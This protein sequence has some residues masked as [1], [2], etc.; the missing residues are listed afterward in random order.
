MLTYRTGAIAGVSGGKAMAAH[1]MEATLPREAA[2]LAA[3]YRAGAEVLSWNDLIFRDLA[4]QVVSGTLAREDAEAKGVEIENQI[5]PT[6]PAAKSAGLARAKLDA[7][8]RSIGRGEQAITA[9]EPRADM[10]PALA[11]R[12]GIDPTRSLSGDELANLLAGWCADG[13]PIEGASKR[14]TISFVDCCFSADKSVSLAWAFAPTE[15]ERNQIAQAHRD[16]VQSAMA[17]ASEQ[18]GRA[19]KGN[20]GKGGWEP[21]HVG[22]AQFMHYTSRPTLEI[23]N[24]AETELVSL[25]V[26]GDPNLHTHVTLFNAVLTDS[27]RFGSLDLQRLKGRVHEFGAYYQAHL[28]QNLRAIGAD[29]MLDQQTGAARLAAIPEAV[30]TAF[31]KRTV[32]A[33]TIARRWAAEAGR[34]WDALPPEEKIELAKRG[35]GVGRQSKNAKRDD[36]SDFTAWNEQADQLGWQ[37]AG[38]LREGAAPAAQTREERTGQAYRAAL[39]F[40]EKAFGASAVVDMAEL[41]V[42][43][44]R[45]LIAASV[46]GPEDITAVV[47]AFGA[48]GVRQGGEQTRLIAARDGRWAR[49]TTAKHLGREEELVA[50]AQAAAADC[51]A[52]LPLAAIERAVR[53]TDLD[54]STSHGEQQRAVIERL[55]T[56]GRVGVA[57][58]VAG[59][60]KTSLLAPLVD[61]WNEAGRTVLGAAVAWRQVDDLADAGINNR[62]ALSVLLDRAES[63]KLGLNRD[64]VI[65]VDELGQVGTYEMARLLRLQAASGAHVIAVGDHRQCQAVEAGPTIELLRKALGPDQ[66]PELLTTVRQQSERERETSLLFRDGKAGAALARKDEDGTLELVPGGYKDAVR[67]AADLWAERQQANAGDKSYRL[68][69]TAPTNEDARAISA[70]IRERMRSAGQLEPDA[71]TV[72]ATDQNGT[73]YDLALARG[74]RIRLFANTPAALSGGRGGNIGRNG[75]VLTVLDLSAEGVRMRNAKGTEGLVKWETLRDPLSGRARLSYGDC[76]TINA[77]QGVTATEH[78]NALPGGSRTANANTVYVAESRHRRQSWLVTS[79]GAE[80]REIADRRPLGDA[81]PIARKDVL[82]NMSRNLSRQPEKPSALLF[83]ER[84]AQGVRQSARGFQR[85]LRPAEERKRAGQQ[86]TTLHRSFARARLRAAAQAVKARVL[87]A[88]EAASQAYAR[89]RKPRMRRAP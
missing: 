77:A 40:V 43:A 64:T 59:A 82:A 27:G 87:T 84:A 20:G 13:E 18:L 80:R 73:E 50:L 3:Y 36:R 9:A 72:K 63:G 26:A 53:R 4:R 74:D 56:G 38:V 68:T 37:H 67:R 49:A 11:T 29:V 31:S 7:L 15:A 61:A 35:S 55:A 62:Y 75:S 22:W 47:R 42:A 58:G 33:V 83:L 44:T 46:D 5:L 17:Y 39:P 45:G 8:I 88:V 52:A 65:V 25:K 85:G 70:A 32:D 89:Q 28:A 21:G 78:I 66:V 79:D 48:R 41:R 30:R 76:L 6:Q 34:D 24:G 1:L 10:H 69:V 16:A 23:A 81:R 71:V 57:I 54:L 19:R 60:G 14:R 51:T 2:D 12:L 86:P